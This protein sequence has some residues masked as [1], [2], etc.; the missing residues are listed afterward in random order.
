MTNVHLSQKS[1]FLT[2]FPTQIYNFIKLFLLLNHNVILDFLSKLQSGET[3]DRKTISTMLEKL[4][5]LFY[6]FKKRDIFCFT[7]KSE[8]QTTHEI[9]RIRDGGY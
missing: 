4:R 5:F 9:E 2:W 1:S 6:F 8:G 3:A 7:K